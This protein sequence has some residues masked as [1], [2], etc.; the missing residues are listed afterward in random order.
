MNALKFS[1]NVSYV[2][3]Y[4]GFHKF[5]QK[6]LCGMVDPCSIVGSGV[7]LPEFI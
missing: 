3:V 4:V 7:E 1:A 2:R 5:Y 6:K